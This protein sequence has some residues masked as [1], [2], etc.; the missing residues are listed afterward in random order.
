MTGRDG[1]GVR[2]PSLPRILPPLAQGH[3]IPVMGRALP[4]ASYPRTKRARNGG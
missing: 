1:Y 2:Q 3:G 4:R